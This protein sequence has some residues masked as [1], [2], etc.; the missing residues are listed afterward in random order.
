MNNNN[1]KIQIEDNGIGIS[2][3]HLPKIFE[4]FYRASEKS[5]GSGLGLYIVKETLEKLKGSI[6]VKSSHG[7]GSVFSVEVPV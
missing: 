2:D 4:M 1:L 6:H 5:Q 3:E 7:H